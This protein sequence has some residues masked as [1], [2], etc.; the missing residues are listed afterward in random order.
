MR[1]AVRNLFCAGIY[2]AARD[3]WQR[4]RSFPSD[5]EAPTRLSS[6]IHQNPDKSA[7]N[8]L[9]DAAGRSETGN[10]VTLGRLTLRKDFL[11]LE[12]WSMFYSVQLVS[13]GTYK[14]W[15]GNYQTIS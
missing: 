11:K 1:L 7:P 6:L 12:L 15:R 14:L 8:R 2:L 5:V 4:R 10:L 3:I 9:R 13:R